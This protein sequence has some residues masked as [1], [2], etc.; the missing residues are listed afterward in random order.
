MKHIV[1]LKSKSR[2]IFYHFHNNKIS[3]FSKE[4]KEK[5]PE[6]NEILF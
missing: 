4:R 3:V 2:T 6:N 1:V 5:K